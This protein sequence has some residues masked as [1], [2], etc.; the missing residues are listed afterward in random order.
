MSG[1][2]SLEVIGNPGN[3]MLVVPESYMEVTDEKTGE[4]AM[5]SNLKADTREDK[6]WAVQAERSWKQAFS[7]QNMFY[8]YKDYIGWGLV[9]FIVILANFVGFSYLSGKL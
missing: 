2:N 4:T 5:F 8:E 1:D 6:A 7:V 3:W 9:V